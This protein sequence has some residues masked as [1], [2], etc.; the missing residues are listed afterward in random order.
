VFHTV[1]NLPNWFSRDAVTVGAVASGVG[2]ALAM[3][4]GGMLGG[5]TGARYHERI[6]QLIADTR[7]GAIPSTGARRVVRPS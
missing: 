3:L 7:P 2:A 6:D 1:P 5:R 4:V